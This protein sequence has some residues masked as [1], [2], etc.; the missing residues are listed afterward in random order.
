MTNNILKRFQTLE[1]SLILYIKL[2]TNNVNILI[3]ISLNMNICEF[4]KTYWQLK[5]MKSHTLIRYRMK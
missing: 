2:F 3:N 4:I 5:S 1:K